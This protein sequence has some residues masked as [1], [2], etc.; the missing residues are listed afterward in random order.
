[1]QFH[2]IPINTNFRVSGAAGMNV[3]LLTKIAPIELPDE[4]NIRNAKS[5]SDEPS[6]WYCPYH[7]AVE[8]AISPLAVKS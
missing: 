2:E 6:Y 5:I 1:M 3:P 7:L 8:M 4:P